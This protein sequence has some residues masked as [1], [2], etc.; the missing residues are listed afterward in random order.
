MNDKLITSEELDAIVNSLPDGALGYCKTWGYKDLAEK[1]IEVLME[2]PTVF[3]L[4]ALRK[5][6]QDG[7]DDGYDERSHY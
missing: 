5:A 1:V 3:M 7:Y 6:R 4:F 2:R